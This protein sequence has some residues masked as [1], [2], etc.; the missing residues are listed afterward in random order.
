MYLKH[1]YNITKSKCRDKTFAKK[2]FT[3]FTDAATFPIIRFAKLSLTFSFCFLSLKSCNLFLISSS[4]FCWHL[5][6]KTLYS[7]KTKPGHSLGGKC[8]KCSEKK[9]GT[10]SY[11]QNFEAFFSDFVEVKSLYI[12]IGDL[13]T[14][15]NFR[16]SEGVLMRN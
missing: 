3:N 1:S 4:L 13:S 12:F 15:R 14:F 10:I 11:F 8:M 16:K 5:K 2:I 7:L 9:S 6:Y